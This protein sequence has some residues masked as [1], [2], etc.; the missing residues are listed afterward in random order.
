VGSILNVCQVYQKYMDGLVQHLEPR[1]CS[2]VF[3]PFMSSV[4]EG[5]N[6]ENVMHLEESSGFM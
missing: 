3:P 5:E 4:K 2:V 6:E 1:A